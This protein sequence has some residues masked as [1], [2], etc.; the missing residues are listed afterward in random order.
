MKSFKKFKI[1]IYFF[2]FSE[3]LSS[4]RIEGDIDNDDSFVSFTEMKLDQIY[5]DSFDLLKQL[6]EFDKKYNAS[7][8]NDKKLNKDRKEKITVLENKSW[9]IL[10]LLKKKMN[11]DPRHFIFSIG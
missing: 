3:P 8:V 1:L 10:G 7:F 2:K 4:Q 11:E 9:E 6:K 5:K